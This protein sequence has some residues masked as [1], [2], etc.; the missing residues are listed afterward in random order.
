MLY[1]AQSTI[2]RSMPVVVYEHLDGWNVTQDMIDSM[3]VTKEVN[4]DYG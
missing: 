1:G 2:R 3:Q 4:S